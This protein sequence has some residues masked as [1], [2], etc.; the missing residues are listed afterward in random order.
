MHDSS[1]DALRGFEDRPGEHAAQEAE[2]GEDQHREAHGPAGLGWGQGFPGG[3]LAG[4]EAADH[5]G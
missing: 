5:D 2:R 4:E 3:F 1:G